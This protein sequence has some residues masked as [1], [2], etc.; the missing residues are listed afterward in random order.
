M[1]DDDT[2]K[3]ILS[4][5]RG[6]FYSNLFEKYEQNIFTTNDEENTFIND[7][8]STLQD[9]IDFETKIYIIRC[10]VVDVILHREIDKDYYINHFL[11]KNQ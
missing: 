10:I 1:S 11:K 6:E 7:L 9:D 4:D 8:I 3:Q 2:K 5:E